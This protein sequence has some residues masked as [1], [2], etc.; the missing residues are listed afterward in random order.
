MDDPWNGQRVVLLDLLLKILPIDVPVAMSSSK[1]TLPTIPRMI[2]EFL[3]R[4]HVTP[5]PV[6]LVMSPE[7]STQDGMLLL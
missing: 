6:V 4:S 5:Y 3:Q 7:F 1:P 2:P